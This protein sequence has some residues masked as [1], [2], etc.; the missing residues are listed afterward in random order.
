MGRPIKIEDS[1]PKDQ[2]LKF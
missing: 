2:L 1:Q